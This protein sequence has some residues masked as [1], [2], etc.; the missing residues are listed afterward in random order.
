V[1]SIVG[2]I[3]I[4][5]DL[6]C[7]YEGHAFSIKAAN[8]KIVIEVS[9]LITAIRLIRKFPRRK[10][11]QSDL[12]QLG[13]WLVS[14]D[15]MLE[16]RVDGVCVATA[17]GGGG[18]FLGYLIGFDRMRLQPVAVLRAALRGRR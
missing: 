8:G 5:A 16:F 14:L 2:G 7:E 10:N 17:D 18:S 3:Q 4:D 9:D 15:N 12:Q 6:R 11:S 13:V 1:R